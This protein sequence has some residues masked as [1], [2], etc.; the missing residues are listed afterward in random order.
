MS[1]RNRVRRALRKS[2]AESVS[3]TNSNAT[4]STLPSETSSLR[5]TPTTTSTLSRVL[6]SLGSRD[7]SSDRSEKK[8]IRDER[9]RGRGN[10]KNPLHPSLRPL[11]V[12][13]LRH[14]EMLSHYTLTFGAS[15]PSQIESP[16]FCGVSP[17]CTR[18]PSIHLDRDDDAGLSPLSGLSVADTPTS[19]SVQ[20]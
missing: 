14:Q 6:S 18:P 11:T 12:E 3:P 20:Q 5:K 19:I 4:S 10:A 13:N 16:S 2:R 9:Q 17:C 8:R 15:D 7:K 1:I